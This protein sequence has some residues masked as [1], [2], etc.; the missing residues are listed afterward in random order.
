MPT[1]RTQSARFSRPRPAHSPDVIVLGGGII[2]LACACELARHH[3]RV[4]V[5]ERHLHGAEASMAA[6]GMLAPLAEVPNPSPMFTACRDARDLWRS[7]QATLAAES[8]MD[9]DYDDSGALMVALDRRQALELKR[10]EAAATAL[11]EPCF[12]L[13]VTEARRRIPHLPS[14][15]LAACWLPGEHRVD[16]VKVCA[17]LATTAERLGVVLHRGEEVLR[18]RVEPGEVRVE[19]SE[20]QREAGTLVLAAGAWSGSIAGLPPLPVEPIRGQMLLLGGV[21]W[22]FSGILRG[23]G[24]Y[25][26]RRGESCLLVG[27]TSER[28]GFAPHTTPGGISQLAAGLGRLLP[29]L[30]EHRLEASWAGLRPGTPDGLPLLG[31]IGDLPVLAATGHYRNGILLAPWTARRITDWVLDGGPAQDLSAFAPNRFL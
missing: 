20:S 25:T 10:L 2:G 30:C 13:E 29:G 28:V 18:V 16:N 14:R 17:A 31:P 5:F 26:V 7:F 12:A 19:T 27:A 9:L 22:S 11:G 15:L 8:E 21:D 1:R 23:G 24:F 6:A 3:L 4:E